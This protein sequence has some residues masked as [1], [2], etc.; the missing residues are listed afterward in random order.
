MDQEYGKYQV[1]NPPHMPDEPE[2][3]WWESVLQDEPFVNKPLLTN[4]HIKIKNFHN[5]NKSSQKISID[6]ETTLRN[7]EN[8]EIVF[9]DVV[10]YNQGGLLVKGW[11]I[12]GF[13]PV[14]H[15]VDL[16]SITSKAKREE[17]LIHYLGRQIAL[18]IIECEP[19]KDRIILS[20]RAALAGAGQRKKLLNVLE[21]DD[22]VNG[23]VTNVT[24]FGA[25]VD[26]GGLEGLIHLSE[27][28]WGRVEHPSTILKVDDKVKVL[29][30]DIS[31][32]DSKIA[33][34]LK[35]LQK[36]PWEELSNSL[37]PG[38]IVNAVITSIVNYGAFAQLE[39][40]VEG[41]IHVNSMKLPKDYHR[42]DQVLYEG[43]DVKV[44][45]LCID[46]KARRLGLSL[47]GF[48]EEWHEGI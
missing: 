13:V 28:S 47:E 5:F 40:G 43:Q 33:L 24:S 37:Q 44:K 23:V 9:L 35:R 14:S 10:S 42:I 15:L 25:F 11:G 41:L 7:F 36:N 17:H 22:K 46:E 6:W 1:E 4:E 2:E 8:D 16:T 39:V 34:S 27:L 18:K 20:E 29:I 3:T 12:H 21:V 32:D 38:D 48:L 26:L 31:K 45:V 30:I 19:H